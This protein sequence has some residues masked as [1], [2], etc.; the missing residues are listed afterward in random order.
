MHTN[1]KNNRRISFYPQ[2]P[3]AQKFSFWLFELNVSGFISF[4][5]QE[6]YWAVWI[7]RTV[8]NNKVAI[9]NLCGLP[10][11]IEVQ[12]SIYISKYSRRKVGGSTIYIMYAFC[13]ISQKS[14][15][16]FM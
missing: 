7:I 2:I 4:D 11:H 5:G 10:C 14:E 9:Y 12:T 3:G 13:Y 16:Q 8:H 1:E 6:R 15:A